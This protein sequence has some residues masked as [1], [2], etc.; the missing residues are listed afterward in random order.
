MPTIYRTKKTRQRKNKDGTD[1]PMPVCDV[2]H[3]PIAVGQPHKN[4][5]IRQGSMFVTKVR[6][7][8]EPDWHIWELSD[9]LSA[10]LAHV[11]YDFDQA[12]SGTYDSVDDVT[13]ALEE[14][15]SAVREIAEE[16]RESASNIE[17][18]FGHATQQSDE[19]NEVAD[20]LESWADEI[21]SAD[22]PELPEPE[23]EDCDV[24]NG[25]VSSG[26]EKCHGTGVFTP[27]APTEDQL[28]EWRDL[29]RDAVSIVEE[30]PV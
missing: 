8:N 17:D 3:K 11:A 13:S 26:C 20:A 10:R 12:L 29:V 24:C 19:L 6:C 18:G 30:S 21:E 7:A 9:S 15:A 1:A 5:S 27:D 23:E 25:N 16:K 22:V 4:V 2:C 28:E 14:A